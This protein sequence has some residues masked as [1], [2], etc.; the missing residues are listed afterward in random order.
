[1]FEDTT[2]EE[3]DKI[4]IS[5]NTLTANVRPY[6]LDSTPK[7]LCPD[8]YF[9]A[10]STEAPPAGQPA[11]TYGERRPSTGIQFQQSQVDQEGQEDGPRFRKKNGADEDGAIKSFSFCRSKIGCGSRV[12]GVKISSINPA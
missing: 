9:A 11:K 6:A 7:Q 10:G 4:L 8:H 1:T 3:Y 5:N 2:T 12:R